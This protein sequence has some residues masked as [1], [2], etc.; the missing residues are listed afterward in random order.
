MEN[1]IKGGLSDKMSLEDIAK[2]HSVDIK[3]LKK[4]LI[5]GIKV[6]MEHT[7]DPKLSKEISYDHLSEDPKYYDKLEKCVEAKEQTMSGASGS[8]EAPMGAGAVKR[9]IGTIH[10]SEITE[11][12][13]EDVEVKKGEQKEATTSAVSAGAQYDVPLG[14][15]GRHAKTKIRTQE[16]ALKLDNPDSIKASKIGK[17]KSSPYNYGVDV[18][19]KCRTFPYCNQGDINALQITKLSEAI[20]VV[21]KERGIP[22]EDVEKIVLKEI[23]DIFMLYETER[24]KQHN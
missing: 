16:D 14:G 15:S 4:Q 6:E 3:E 8:F 24:N 20:N 10:N 1:Q 23:R 21:A 2:K 12:D 13:E 11:E 5:K 19:E 22:V 17:K 18:K 9:P 7:N